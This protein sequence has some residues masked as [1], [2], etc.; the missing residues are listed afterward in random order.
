[1]KEFENAVIKAI[2][3]VLKGEVEEG[4]KE[5]KLAYKELSKVNGWDTQRSDKDELNWWDFQR[6]INQR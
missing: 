5:L 1:M 6:L 2:D 4:K 3:K